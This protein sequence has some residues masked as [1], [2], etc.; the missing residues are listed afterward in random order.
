MVQ[1]TTPARCYENSSECMCISWRLAQHCAHIFACE[2]RQILRCSRNQT[3]IIV[4]LMDLLSMHPAT[5]DQLKDTE[6]I[7]ANHGLEGVLLHG[8]IPDGVIGC[9]MPQLSVYDRLNMKD[10]LAYRCA[11]NEAWPPMLEETRQVLQ[12]FYQPFNNEMALLL[13]DD[14][15]AWSAGGTSQDA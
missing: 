3:Q 11:A 14:S 12:D 1:V 10:W 5:S 2:E 13:S 8:M 15:F 6:P 7:S 4:E 9:G